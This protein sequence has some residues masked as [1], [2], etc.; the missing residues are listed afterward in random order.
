MGVFKALM[1]KRLRQIPS[2]RELYQRLWDDPRLREICE[3]EAREKP[4]PPSQLT[5]FRRWVGPER[6]ERIMG[7]LVDELMDGCIISGETV[8]MDANFIK[9]YSKRDLYDNRRGSSYPDARVGRD[10]RTYDLG[11]KAHIAAGVDSDLPLAFTTA[12]ANDN[13]KKRA[14]GLL[15]KTME[16]AK[17]WVKGV[18]LIPGTPAEGSGERPPN[19]AWRPSSRIRPTRDRARTCSE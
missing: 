10:W 4:Y 19:A 5:R 13:E 1:V 6:L 15:D 11:Y 14:P 3:I 12:P 2:D 8:T 17:K 16:A 7:R 18:W 9:A